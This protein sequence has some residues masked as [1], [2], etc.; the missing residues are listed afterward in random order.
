MIF[1][2]SFAR[3]VSSTLARSLARSLPPSLTTHTHTHTRPLWEKRTVKRTGQKSPLGQTGAAAPAACRRRRLGSPSPGPHAETACARSAG[4]YGPA[5]GGAGQAATRMPARQGRT[6][7]SDPCPGADSESCLS[8]PVFKFGR[9]A[10]W[11]QTLRFG[12]RRRRYRPWQGWRRGTG[13]RRP[14]ARRP[15][16]AASAAGNRDAR[17]PRLGQ[18]QDPGPASS[19]GAVSQS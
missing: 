4:W 7:I 13:S 17:P 14:A 6:A 1:S 18:L 3:S 16:R 19:M 9:T 8:V 10:S 15:S 12:R 5:G 2:L 11:R